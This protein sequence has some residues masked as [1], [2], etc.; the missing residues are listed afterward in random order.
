MEMSSPT[1]CTIRMRSVIHLQPI[2]WTWN[3]TVSWRGTSEVKHHP[4]L[5][6]HQSISLMIPDQPNTNT[7]STSTD[8]LLWLRIS[9]HLLENRP[10]ARAHQPLG[11]RLPHRL[12]A[13]MTGRPCR[14]PNLPR[15]RPSVRKCNRNRHRSQNRNQSRPSHPNHSQCRKIVE[16][17]GT[18]LYPCRPLTVTMHLFRCNIRRTLPSRCQSPPMV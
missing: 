10:R 12:P 2:C 16:L 8:L 3:E 5:S 13:P 18:I 6:I 15:R 7:R 14:I 11:H 9:V 1:I 17:S 4:S